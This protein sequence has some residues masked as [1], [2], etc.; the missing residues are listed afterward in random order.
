MN[1]KPTD[2]P[3]IEDATLKACLDALS[4]GAGPAERTRS[5]REQATDAPLVSGS[6]AAWRTEADADYA[7]LHMIAQFNAKTD[8]E[9]AAAAAAFPRQVGG[10]R[11]RLTRME[12]RLAQRQDAVTALLDRLEA[13][14]RDPD[15]AAEVVPLKP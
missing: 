8:A 10:M 9:L 13:I 2:L 3:D 7:M 4:D 5:A 12:A 15:Q 6:L 1:R 11:D 14:T